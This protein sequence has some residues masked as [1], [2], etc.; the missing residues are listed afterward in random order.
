MK[1]NRLTNFVVLDQAPST[2]PQVLF[3]EEQ[4]PPPRQFLEGN[5][6]LREKN[7]LGYI[8]P[9]SPFKFTSQEVTAPGRSE[10]WQV[11][12]EARSIIL[13]G[14]T[15][16][17]KKYEWRLNVSPISR[18]IFEFIAISS[19]KSNHPPRLSPPLSSNLVRKL[20]DN[21]DSSFFSCC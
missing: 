21:P 19:H 6:L 11:Q 5:F 16:N 7:G 17:G 18:F 4:R 9:V 8:C 13:M 1:L 12:G 3:L 20:V 10:L 2:P 15:P 14:I